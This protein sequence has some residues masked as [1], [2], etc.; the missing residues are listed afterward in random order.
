[1][2][3]DKQEHK[4]ALIELIHKAQFFGGS[5][6]QVVELLE[7]VESATIAPPEKKDAA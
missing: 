4:D 1:M 7:A 6:K 3:L 5:A 2:T